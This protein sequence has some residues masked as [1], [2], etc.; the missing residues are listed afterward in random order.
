MAA[1]IHIPIAQSFAHCTMRQ[2]CIFGG[3]FKNER[4]DKFWWKSVLVDLCWAPGEAVHNT[5]HVNVFSL[6]VRL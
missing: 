5:P 4:S 6:C 3:E 2:I 1:D